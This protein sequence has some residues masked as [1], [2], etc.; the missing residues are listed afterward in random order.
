MLHALMVALSI[1]PSPVEEAVERLE[2]EAIRPVLR[3][4]WI[5]TG[6]MEENEHLLNGFWGRQYDLECLQWRLENTPADAP[7]L[8]AIHHLPAAVA[9]DNYVDGNAYIR[10]LE[11]QK[12]WCLP[13]YEQN[14]IEWLI[15]DTKQRQ[16][17]WWALYD[18][19]GNYFGMKGRRWHLN[20]LRKLV[21]EGVFY[22]REP[23]PEPL[24]PQ[25][26][27]NPDWREDVPT[28][29]P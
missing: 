10:W 2:W 6:L 14:V 1:T 11:G 19:T 20:E 7:P 28:Y 5:N 22:G 3:A 8:Q 21:G 29:D 27:L 26:Y 18:C 4:Y 17:V 9:V 23:W 15:L 12:E 24:P 25:A 13:G 16:K